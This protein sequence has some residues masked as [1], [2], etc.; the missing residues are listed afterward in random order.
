MNKGTWYTTYICLRCHGSLFED[1]ITHA[2]ND[3]Y[4]ILCSL[5]VHHIIK[6]AYE[7]EEISIGDRLISKNVTTEALE[8][9]GSALNFIDTWLKFFDES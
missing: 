1:F 8:A 4:N 6:S 9:L 5:V 2:R 7:D 3:R